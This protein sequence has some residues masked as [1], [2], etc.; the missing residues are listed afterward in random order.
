MLC[1][2]HNAC[3]LC[4]TCA[5]W[6]KQTGLC[7]P[8]SPFPSSGMHDRT[9]YRYFNDVP[10]SHGPISIIVL[11]M[12]KS[13]QNDSWDLSALLACVALYTLVW[14]VLPN[15]KIPMF[16]EDRMHTL[17]C[18]Q[19]TCPAKLHE[20]VTLCL[21]GLVA[22]WYVDVINMLEGRMH[23]ICECFPGLCASSCWCSSTG[24]DKSVISS[25]WTFKLFSICSQDK[26]SH[27]CLAEQYQHMVLCISLHAPCFRMCWLPRLGG[28]CYV[29]DRRSHWNWCPVLR[30]T[31]IELNSFTWALF[32]N[33]IMALF[34]YLVLW[35]LRYNKQFIVLELTT[36]CLHMK[37]RRWRLHMPHITGFLRADRRDLPHFLGKKN[38]NS[39]YR[40]H[41]Q[42]YII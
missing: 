6:I 17:C 27:R 32:Q 22:G 14:L 4:K 16:A 34:A 2:R 41:F 21:P 18:T 25:M 13:G 23:A 42:N 30:S 3:Q 37:D 9:A 38:H 35:L 40:D 10:W 28:P 26:T 19:V 31:G 15:T 11:N 24:W 29:L 12:A 7:A 33:G 8:G 39:H 1:V 5:Y 20:P 36:N